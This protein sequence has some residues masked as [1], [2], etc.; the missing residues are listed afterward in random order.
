MKMNPIKKYAGLGLAA[1]IIGGAATSQAQLTTSYTN[2]F[3]IGANTASF[4]GSGSVASWIYWYN[5]PGGNAPMTCVVGLDANN[6]TATSGCLE[7]D[8]P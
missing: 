5:T 1:L 7:M 6:N 8:S 2:T 4:S 3:P